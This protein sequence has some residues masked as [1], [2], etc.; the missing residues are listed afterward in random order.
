MFGLRRFR[1]RTNYNEMVRPL[2]LRLL[3][4]LEKIV[5]LEQFTV[6]LKDFMVLCEVHWGKHIEDPHKTLT[7]MIKDLHWFQEVMVISSERTRTMCFIKGVYDELFTDLFMHTTKEYLCFLEYPATLYKD[8]A[9]V[10]LIGHPKEVLRLLKFMKD[11]G[12]PLEIE[13]I[14]EYHS[15]DRG[16][17]SGLTDKQRS[18]LKFAYQRGFFDHPRKADARKLSAKLGMKHTTF[19][20]HIRKSQK[21]MFDE[22]F[23]E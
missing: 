2:A 12:G 4:D 10:N 16:V 14:T 15:R 19:L 6:S 3:G 23:G 21:R 9:I 8:H 22:L 1:V 7:E 20:T 5:V 18:V 11:W 17:L 13:A